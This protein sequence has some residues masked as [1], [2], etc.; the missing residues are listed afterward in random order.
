MR[1]LISMLTGALLVLGSLPA[2]AG[3]SCGVGGNICIYSGTVKQVYMRSSDDLILICFDQDYG[4]EPMASLFPTVT[5]G[6]AAGFVLTEDPDFAEI[7]HSSALSALVAGKNVILHLAGTVGSG[8]QVWL[9]VW[10]IWV[11]Q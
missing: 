11:N 2:L 4:T 5:K 1:F 6:N 3:F 7:L 10:K 8:S 9:K